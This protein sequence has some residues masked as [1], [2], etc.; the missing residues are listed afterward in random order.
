MAGCGLTNPLGCAS[1]ALG[2]AVSGAFGEAL[3][4]LAKAVS[5]AV[6]KVVAALGTVWVHV[7]TPQ[8]TTTNGGSA[9]SDAV[10]FIQ[11]SLWWYTAAAA[12]LAVIVGGGRIAWERRA[13]PAQDLLRGLLTRVVVTGTGLTAIS[14]LVSASDSFA[15]WII[16]RS[17]AGTDFGTNITTMLGLSGTV[18]GG[19]GPLLAV[20]LGLL[21]L[22]ASA[23]QIMLMVVRGGMLVVLAGVLPLSASFTNTEMGRGWFRK[24]VSWTV[25]FTLY[26]PA[27][28][29]V[30][31]TAFRL[32]GSHVDGLGDGAGLVNV[33]TGLVLMVMALFALPALMR[34]VTPLVS[35]VASGS[36]GGGAAL[37]AAAL[38]TGAVS[39]GGGKGSTGSQI[40]RQS[41]PVSPQGSGP[42]GSG[43][44]SP[45]G[46]GSAGGGGQGRP[47]SGGAPS[48]DA[49]SSGTGGGRSSGGSTSPTGADG[50][51]AA[52]TAGS[53]SAA[54]AAPA[55]GAGAAG[56][57]ASG[58][59]TAAAGAG[60]AGAAVVAGEAALRAVQGAA[61]NAAGQ[62]GSGSD[63]KDGPRG[64]A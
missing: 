58:V 1:G 51:V 34:F 62:S 23:V 42:S 63:E 15:G 43:P 45:S 44:G 27:A 32:T 17:T 24:C 14:L 16:D 46:P 49:A 60:P 29:I 50:Q 8:L 20:I 64:S 48:G 18:T 22:L 9:P 47:P 28:A 7:G 31:A 36:G 56:A 6:G 13:A 37:A 61:Q 33:L 55:A 52:G 30:Y 3:D 19:L 40:P 53:P 5:E 41:A 35:T 11:G 21:A 38:P 2:G 39:L 59:G 12:V 25:A 57:G 4:G 10:G 26:K 54:G